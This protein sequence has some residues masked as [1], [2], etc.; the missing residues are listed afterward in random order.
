MSRR[1]ECLSLHAD[2][3]L[4]H[5]PHKSPIRSHP[6]NP[7]PLSGLPFWAS[8]STGTLSNLY[9]RSST[10]VFSN[11][12]LYAFSQYENS[13]QKLNYFWW[14]HTLYAIQ[15]C[16]FVFKKRKRRRFPRAKS[17]LY[18]FLVYAAEIYIIHKINDSLF[19]FVFQSRLLWVR[20]QRNK[21]K[22]L[23]KLLTN[24]MYCGQI[25]K[26]L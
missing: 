12:V 2:Q 16:G 13:S 23:P 24:N 8:Q 11:G 15:I 26:L 4:T 9:P 7:P 17:L 22:S 19:H 10:L 5:H 3:G 25:F 21:W 20:P 18:G 1:D 14:S 6:K